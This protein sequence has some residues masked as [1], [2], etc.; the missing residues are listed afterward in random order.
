MA[1][2]AT[3]DV[4]DTTAYEVAD[5]AS[6]YGELMERTLA[7]ITA[8]EEDYLLE[9]TEVDTTLGQGHVAWYIAYRTVA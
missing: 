3:A 7:E 1:D 2:T 9:P 5:Y 8:S 6:T 4:L